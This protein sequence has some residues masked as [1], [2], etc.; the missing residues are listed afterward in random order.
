MVTVIKAKRKSPVLTPSSLACL[1]AIPTINLTAGCLHDCAYC[2]IR[3]YSTFPGEGRL[4]L[5]ENTLEKLRNELVRRH[6]KP[7]AVYFS[8]SSDLFQPTS[9]VLELAEA[10]LK[11]LFAE[12]IGVAILTKGRI[13]DHMLQLLIDHSELV[14]A[15]IGL[16]SLDEDISRAFEVN[17]AAPRRRLEQMEALIARGVATEARLD[18]ILP[19]LT[20]APDSADRLFAALAQVGVKR[21]A[22]GV[23]FL[24]PAI[25]ESLRRNVP[26]KEMLARLLA[27]YQQR[28]RIGIRANGSSV[29]TLPLEARRRIFA[30][31]REAAAPHNIE[32]SVCA[33]KNPDLAHGSCNIGGT[34]SRQLPGAVQLPLVR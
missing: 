31:M 19:T 33:C 9:E 23:L 16:V 21:V 1:S 13:P 18:P 10:I 2:Y 25:A 11:F 28:E 15:Q 3:G 7:R 8:P 22:A 30:R 34:W 29:Q 5:Y 32:L 27:A 12:G 4:I 6:T 20:D 14:R 17:A 24:R 26:E